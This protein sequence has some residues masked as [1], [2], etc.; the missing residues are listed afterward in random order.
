VKAKHT[1]A[2]V[3]PEAYLHHFRSNAVKTPAQNRK[4]DT[5]NNTHLEERCNM[6]F[7]V[8]SSVFFIKLL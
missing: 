1:N 5:G 2:Q 7:H 8:I 3:Q 4:G 6:A